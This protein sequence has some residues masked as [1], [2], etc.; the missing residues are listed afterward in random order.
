M[1][2]KPEKIARETSAVLKNVNFSVADIFQKK[3]EHFVS[4]RAEK[5]TFF[6][7]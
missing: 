4:K 6:G 5:E 3:I 7:P 2:I 1:H